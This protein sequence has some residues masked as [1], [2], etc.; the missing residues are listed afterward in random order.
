MTAA[1]Q[2][3]AAVRA[4]D[5]EQVRALVQEDPALAAAADE[6]GAPAVRVALYHRQQAVLEALLEAA[7][8]L[9]DPDVAAVGD[10]RELRRRLSRD[11][12]LIRARTPDGF[13]PLHY[14]AFFG[15][16]DAVDALLDA[17]AD[18]DVVAENASRVRPLHSAA[19][20]RDARAADRL[21]AGGADPDAQQEGGY[22]ALHAAAQHDDEELAVVLL[23][24]GADPAIRTDDGADAAALAAARDST[25]VLALLGVPEG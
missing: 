3:I 16:V 15:G 13:T 8:P 5:A 17:G 14:A 19:A 4:G 24:H 10:V 7:P 2:L 20:A 18:P 11:E 1:E 12:E 25:A 6:T 22:T 21:L 9:E 23:R